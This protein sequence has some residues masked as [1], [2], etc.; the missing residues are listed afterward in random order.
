MGIESVTQCQKMIP[1]NYIQ[2]SPGS[3]VIVVGDIH[4]CWLELQQLMDKIKFSDSD[5]LIT[6]GDFLDRGPDSWKIAR[7]IKDTGNVYSVIGN[8]ERRVAGTIRGTSQPAWSQKDTLSRIPSTEY[9]AWAEWLESLPAV[10]ET[11]DVIVTHARLNPSCPLNQQEVYH[12]V[13]VGGKS[14]NITIGLDGIPSWFHNITFAEKPICIGHIGYNNIELVPKRLY[15]LDTGVV[16][17][18]QL[19]AV[20]LPQFEIVQVSASRNYYTEAY[21]A[22]K[23]KHDNQREKL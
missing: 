14:A 10:I 22:W 8:H 12:T 7:F 1:Y 4:G 5:I 2:T 17:G 6:V 13:A 19:T 3:R 16:S 21:H 15:A 20:V 11:P 9:V 23:S 18:G